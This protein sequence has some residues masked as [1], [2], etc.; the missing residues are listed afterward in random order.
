MG[1]Y[2]ANVRTYLTFAPWL[3]TLPGMGI[4]SIPA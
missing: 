4:A 3:V 1:K 2:A